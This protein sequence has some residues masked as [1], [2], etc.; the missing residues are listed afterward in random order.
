MISC[1]SRSPAA[2]NISIGAERSSLDHEA[3]FSTEFLLVTT[4]VQNLGTP[5]ENIAERYLR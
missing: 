2:K 3:L 4:P 1:G 5:S